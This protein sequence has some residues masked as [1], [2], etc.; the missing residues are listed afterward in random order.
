MSISLAPEAW[1]LGWGSGEVV[2]DMT[3]CLYLHVGNE[4]AAQKNRYC[5]VLYCIESCA[6][7]FSS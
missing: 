5:T 1:N 7:R 4:E 6:L 2:R 3:Y